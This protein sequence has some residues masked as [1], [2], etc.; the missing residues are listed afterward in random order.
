MPQ[1][2]LSKDCKCLVLSLI[3]QKGK[4]EIL[5]HSTTSILH[6]GTTT[7][8]P[9]SIGYKLW[10]LSVYWCYL[11]MCI[12]HWQSVFSISPL[13]GLLMR[14]LTVVLR[15]GSTTWSGRGSASSTAASRRHRTTR[16][17]RCTQTKTCTR[18]TSE[19][20]TL[21]LW[22]L[23][24]TVIST[25]LCTSLIQALIALIATKPRYL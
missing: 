18:N 7:L 22:L 25:V 9:C 5:E 24:I 10:A 12:Q 20:I 2:T 8:N 1:K 21:N 17:K 3:W 14:S 11:S 6:G 19:E 23:Y 15:N 13:A 4:W 16:N